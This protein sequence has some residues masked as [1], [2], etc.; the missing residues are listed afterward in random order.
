M[1]MFMFMFMFM[2]M[3]FNSTVDASELDPQPQKRTVDQVQQ[4]LIKIIS[5]T[6][7]IFSYF[8]YQ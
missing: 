7:I 6:Y 3:L 4:F 2:F 5:L 1:I 8:S